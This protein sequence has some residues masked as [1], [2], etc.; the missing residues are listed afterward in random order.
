LRGKLKKWLGVD[1]FAYARALPASLSRLYS[2]GYSGRS[3]FRG[4]FGVAGRVQLTEEAGRQAGD[5]FAHLV[6][7]VGM[8]LRIRFC[9]CL[10][11]TL[12]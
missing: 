3:T 2:G 1:I 7:L 4:K 12:V 10:L 11:P 9:V 5:I 6:E 8:V